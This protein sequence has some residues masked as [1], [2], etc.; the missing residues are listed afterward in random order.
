MCSETMAC[1]VVSFR[2]QIVDELQCFIRAC[3]HLAHCLPRDQVVDE[4]P[5]DAVQQAGATVSATYTGARQVWAHACSV[6]TLTCIA[7]AI[8]PAIFTLR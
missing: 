8:W 6:S 4:P 2:V 3:T 5:V 7:V 1:V